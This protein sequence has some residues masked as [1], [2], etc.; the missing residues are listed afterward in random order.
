LNSYSFYTR[1]NFFNNNKNFI[2]CLPGKYTIA[3]SND[4]STWFRIQDGNVTALPVASAATNNSQNTSTYTIT[5]SGTATQASN[6]SLT[7]Y[8]TASNAYTY[9]R[10]IVTNLIGNGTYGATSDGALSDSLLQF[11][12]T[13]TFNTA[14]SN[15]YAWVGIGKTNPICPLDISGLTQVTGDVSMNNRLFVSSVGIN[16]STITSGFAL[17]VNGNIRAT[18]TLTQI[19]DYRIKTNVQTIDG[20]FTVDNLRPVSYHNILSNN[21]DF[22]LIAHELQQQYPSLVHGNKDDNDYQSVNYTGLIGVLISEIQQ[23]KKRITKLE[24]TIDPSNNHQNIVPDENTE[25]VVPDENTEP[26]VP[27]DNTEPV[28]PDDNQTV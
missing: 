16:Q 1:N 17:D 14:T 8:S 25:P 5:T 10:I 11:G 22:G 20:T 4:G 27:D 9:F 21:Q 15:P 24:N 28:V 19:S 6:N 26:V 2:G 18:G 7:G 23:L 13:P 3:G 12:W